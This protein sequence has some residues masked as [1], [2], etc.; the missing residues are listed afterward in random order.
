MI[1]FRRDKIG[2]PAKVETI[3][4][5]PNRSAD[6]ALLC[7]ADGERRYILAPHGLAVGQ[8]VVAAPEADIQPGNALPLQSDPAGHDAAQHRAAARAR[9]ARWSARPAPARS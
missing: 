7:Y 8:T 3:E 1:D 6:I 9:A 5:D 2:I 4:Y